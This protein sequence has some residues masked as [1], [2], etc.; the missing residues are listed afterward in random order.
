[1]TESCPGYQPAFGTGQLD[2][3]TYAGFNCN[4]WSAARAADD[5]SCGKTKVAS[6]TVRTWTG[7]TSGGTNLAQVDWALRTHVGI[8]L[9]TRYKYPWS[10]FIRRVQGGA[11]AILQGWYAPIRDSRFG[12]SE[13]FG[14]NHSMLV[15]PGLVV[16]DPLADG[17]RA[18]IYKYHGEAYPE[19]LLRTF[20]ARLNLA[21]PPAYSPL[22]DGLV[23]AAFT[24]DN[25]PDYVVNV[26]PQAGTKGYP[27]YRYFNVFTVSSGVITSS[28]VARTKG[29]SAKADAPRLYKWSGHSSQ[30]LVRIASG[31]REGQY[32]RSAYAHPA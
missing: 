5:D 2:G 32:I 26:R 3:S 21:V 27:T 14:G 11:S 9:D 12:A 10:E 31:Y 28:S 25:E 20:A 29:F 1:M 7:D 16:M 13:T 24:R 6:A 22:G 4:C 19:S 23:Y 15:M 18:G 30:S 8:D 17:R